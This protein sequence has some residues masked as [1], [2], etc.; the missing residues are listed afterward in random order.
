M[1]S[2]VALIGQGQAPKL[3]AHQG[4]QLGLT[5][6]LAPDLST[7]GVRVNAVCPAGVMTLLM[8]EWAAHSS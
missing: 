6:A 4:R 7:D 1:S 8:P 2:E 5:R 3:R